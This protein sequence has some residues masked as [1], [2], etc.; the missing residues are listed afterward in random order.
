MKWWKLRR[1]LRVAKI[2]LA[3]RGALQRW[4]AR[5]VLPFTQAM[6]FSVVGDHF[7]DP[8]PNVK[9]IREHYIDQPRELPGFHANPAWAENIEKV[10]EPYIAEYLAGPAYEKHGKKNWF[11]VEWDAAYYYCLIRSRKPKLITEVG[12]GI[13]TWIAGEALER[14]AA[15]GYPGEIVSIDPYFRGDNSTARTR[16]IQTELQKIAPSEREALLRS[17][18][19]FV[20]SSH[21]AKWGSDVLQIFES[22]IPNVAPKTLVHIHDLWTPYDYP[23][24]F[25][26]KHKRFWNEQYVFESF[27]AFNN[28]FQIECPIFYL[29]KTGKL[30]QL[31]ERVNAPQ[32][33][34]GGGQAMWLTRV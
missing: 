9:Q 1:N 6:G 12:R 34:S 27:I 2:K 19:F 11:Y 5:K 28:A 29:F 26:V 24:D 17:D 7:Y 15:E 13:T 23:K 14:N 18:I 30:K 16:I 25:M 8:V 3:E 32:L 4:M 31:A 20:D 33:A 10:V 22:W 21:I